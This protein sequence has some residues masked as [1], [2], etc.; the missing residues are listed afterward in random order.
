MQTD[1]APAPDVV[2]VSTQAAA[3]ASAAATQAEQPGSVSTQVQ[4]ELGPEVSHAA[5]QADLQQQEAS[6]TQQQQ[7][8]GSSKGSSRPDAAELES[9]K[10]SGSGIVYSESGAELSVGKAAVGQQLDLLHQLQRRS[11]GSGSEAS[12]EAAGAAKD[13]SAAGAAAAVVDIK[14]EELQDMGA[15][16]KGGAVS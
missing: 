1:E 15:V 14:A 10:R 16:A 8:T 13:G 6:T 4:A 5:S 12:S 3:E 7:Q 11:V 2:H 9:I